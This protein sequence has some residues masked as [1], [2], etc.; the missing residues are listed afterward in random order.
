[1]FKFWK[2]PAKIAQEGSPTI[3][4]N[5][6]TKINSMS[7]RWADQLQIKSE[8]LSITGK[9][10]LLLGFV[11]VFGGLSLYVGWRSIKISDKSQPTEID[12]MV[13]SKPSA[14]RLMAPPPTDQMIVS[15]DSYTAIVRFRKYLD[16]LAQAGD[17]RTRDSLVKANPGMLDSMAIIERSY[18]RQSGQAP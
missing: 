13:I 3:A 6:R 12:R 10:V 1:M 9:C 16:S 8:R 17:L 15:P 14:P 18:L 4:S 7:H 11:C 5:V 2:R